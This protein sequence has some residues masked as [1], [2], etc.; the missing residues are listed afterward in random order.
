MKNKVWKAWL[1]AGVAATV[2]VSASLG[3][4]PMQV[5]AENI[6]GQT[7]YGGADELT[8]GTRVS[9]MNGLSE[10]S[11]DGTLK[12]QIMTDSAT[13][14]YFY[15]VEKNGRTI[16]EASQLGIK[17]DED[18]TQKL[19]YVLDSTER[20]NGTETYS[21]T[22]GANR[23]VND[24]YR[25]ISFELAKSGDTSKKIK[26][27]LRVFN[28]G[29]A[30]RYTMY[31]QVG[32]KVSI[33]GE[34][35]EYV[36]P[37]DATVW[38]GDTDANYE[39]EYKKRTMSTIKNLNGNLS[40]PLLAND[41]DIWVLICEGAVYNDP[42]PYCASYLS[43]KS[44]SRNLQVKFGNSQTL[45]VEKTFTEDGTAS[46]PWRVAAIA[47]NLNDIVNAT[48]FT[49]VNPDP[50]PAFY[51]DL[52]Y[53]KPGKAAW[54]WWSES[55]DD[56]VEY[57]QQKDYIDFAAEN[58]WEYVCID[59]GW[60]LWE[61]Y[62][63]KVKE[64]VDYA[65][66]RGV[67]IMLWYGVNNS[68]HSGFKDASGAAAYPKYSLKT[69]EQLEEQFAWCSKMGVRAVKVDYYEK[70]NQST[71]RQMYECA[72]IA[73]KNHINVLFHGC[74]VPRGEQRTFPNVLGYEAVRGAEWYKWNV[75]PSVATDLTYL[76]TRN[77]LG[78]MD[79][80]PP[81]M[82]IDQFNTT[83][84]FQLAQVAAYESGLPSFASSV[85]KL[86][87]F[88]GLAL[89]NDIPVS[90][91]ETVLVDGYPGEYLAVARRSGED[92]YLAVMTLNARSESI[93]L[94][95]LGDGE[96]TAFVFRDNENGTG[97]VTEQ[98]SVTKED[99]LLAELLANGGMTV[100]FTKNGMSLA[101]AYDAYDFY[102]AEDDANE[103]TGSAA[104]VTNQFV[105]GMQR[106]SGIGNSA[107]NTLTFTDVTVPEDGVYELRLYYSTGVERRICFSVNG[108]EAIRTKKLNC[109]VNALSAESFYVE[110]KAGINTITFSNPETKAPDVDRI[111]ISK[112]PTD[113]APTETD[114]TDD[115]I[116]AVDGAQYEYTV[117]A[118]SQAAL[119]G[120][121]VI[122]N[123]GIGWLGNS[124]SCTATFRVTV[125]EAGNYKMR[126]DFYTGE[127]RDLQIKTGQGEALTISCPSTGSYTPESA[128]YIY[129]DVAL[130]KGENQITIF[131][132]AGWAPNILDIG[133][134]KTRTDIPEETEST[135]PEEQPVDQTPEGKSS[136]AIWKIATV[137]LV[138]AAL[139]AALV[140]IRRKKEK[141]EK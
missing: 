126:V 65:E 61:D 19:T 46:T 80:T 115:G 117:Y 57:D 119:A 93:D 4:L 122:E 62:Q 66:A 14:R 29:V 23:E 37:A 86:E 34:A 48:I 58:G 97:I 27:T 91:D 9:A 3:I 69:T 24:P 7:E 21:L 82:K 30:Y 35:S 40:V 102:E 53:I 41:S 124:A 92:W 103:L 59:F 129:L 5:R 99:G 12:A 112:T 81:A 100:K 94:S 125:E 127:T 101:T 63:T 16:L 13:G 2:I 134:S 33:L 111:A 107:E 140:L 32:E 18:Y 38:A 116:E 136:G 50:D 51:S 68:N 120:G 141:K 84:G 137:V 89:M 139:A 26:V 87:G 60:C 83:A 36:L 78:G 130:E 131:N 1:Y 15:T 96:Y 17:A 20:E 95:F 11:P 55:G 47:D 79:Y 45:A 109:G 39:F 133:I 8:D 138:L 98:T 42:D 74:T 123:S 76:F 10:T 85:F 75:G 54:S 31:G 56:P 67:G 108:G 73:A 72:T 77:V 88:E 132:A 121:A 104:I 43:T 25:E 90:W 64:L 118:A 128:D 49:S 110:L 22:S 6:S 71:M 105:S 113:G 135:I 114:E 106:V 28:G 52:S 44:D 70:D